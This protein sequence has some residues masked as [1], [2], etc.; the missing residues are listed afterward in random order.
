MA[1][2]LSQ[3]RRRRALMASTLAH[4]HGWYLF[5]ECDGLT[6][7]IL[8]TRDYLKKQHPGLVTVAD[9]VSRFRCPTC[10]RPHQTVALLRINADHDLW[11]PIIGWRQG[12]IRQFVETHRQK[13]ERQRREQLD[14][15]PLQARS[16]MEPGTE[17][18]AWWRG[19]KI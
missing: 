3:E 1:H 19:M 18:V 13:A 7:K 14:V 2:N 12:D 17:R 16:A 9:L 11:Q 6:H 15:P 5:A 10:G 8:W 4:W